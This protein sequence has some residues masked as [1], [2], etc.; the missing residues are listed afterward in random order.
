MFYSCSRTEDNTSESIRFISIAT[1]YIQMQRWILMKYTIYVS[2]CLVSMNQRV[3][4]YLT[5]YI[6]DIYFFYI[7][8][9]LRNKF[10]F[11]YISQYIFQFIC[12]VYSNEKCYY[13]KSLHCRWRLRVWQWTIITEKHINKKITRSVC[14]NA[15]R[16]DDISHI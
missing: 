8:S 4:L 3:D 12:Y 9:C 2:Y 10:I 1:L 7:Y 15:H 5:H 14:W 11:F 16:K 6:S 13:G